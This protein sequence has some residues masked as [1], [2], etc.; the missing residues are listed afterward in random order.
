MP[1][2]RTP[3]PEQQAQDRDIV[4]G[5]MNVLDVLKVRYPGATEFVVSLE[6]LRQFAKREI[7]TPK[8]KR[9]AKPKPAGEGIPPL[10]GA[11]E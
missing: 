3:S 9:Q 11:M 4:F 6:M 2:R 10:V 1:R 5:V 8:K 7:V